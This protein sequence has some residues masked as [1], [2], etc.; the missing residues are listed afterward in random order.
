MNPFMQRQI[1][2]MISTTTLFVESCRIAAIKDDGTINNEEKKQIRKITEAVA[3]FQEELKEIKEC[4]Y[5]W[6][7]IEAFCKEIEEAIEKAGN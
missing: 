6:D 3:R 1:E 7:E 5:T 2:N 4:D